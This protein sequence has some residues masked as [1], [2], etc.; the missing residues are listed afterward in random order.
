MKRKY[1]LLKKFSVFELAKLRL[2]AK[3]YGD[4]DFEKEILLEFKRRDKER[5]E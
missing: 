2:E 4:K 5:T 1:P 3:E